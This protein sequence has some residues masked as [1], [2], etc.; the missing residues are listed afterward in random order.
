M[1][2]NEIKKNPYATNK[3]GKIQAPNAPS[4]KDPVGTVRKGDD[5][6]K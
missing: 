2:R 5:L 1:K 3:S 4:A 6:R